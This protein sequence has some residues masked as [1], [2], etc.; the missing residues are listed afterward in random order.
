M[1]EWDVT[2]VEQARAIEPV[3]PAEAAQAEQEAEEAA[4]LVD[5]LE[6]RVRQGDPDITPEQIEQQR[7]LAGFAKLRAEAT[8]RRVERARQAARLRELGDL[9]DEMRARSAEDATTYAALLQ[10]IENAVIEL[11]TYTRDRDETIHGWRRIM[12]DQGIP[13]GPGGH[14]R[15]QP[16]HQG[17][18]G[19]GENGNR[20]VFV[21]GDLIEHIEPSVIVVAALRRATTQTGYEL[22]TGA[23]G[24]VIK[25]PDLGPGWVNDPAGQIAKAV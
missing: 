10:T 25:L 24:A 2:T 4:R 15:V 16:E 21:D 7:D 9:A 12:H 3:S 6:E 14:G 18:V 20:P 17:R 8:A 11:V 13:M 5:A 22:R 1:S 19:W 23:G